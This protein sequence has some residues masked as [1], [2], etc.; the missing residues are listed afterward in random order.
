MGVEYK[1]GINKETIQEN[2]AFNAYTTKKGNDFKLRFYASITVHNRE[3]LQMEGI[4]KR[5]R[6]LA[7]NIRQV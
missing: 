1:N 5:V 3:R 4:A 6:K 7:Y 2:R